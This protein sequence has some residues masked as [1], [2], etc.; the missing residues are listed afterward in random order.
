MQSALAHWTGQRTVPNVFI[1]GKH[2]GGCDCMCPF[3]PYLTCWFQLHHIYGHGHLLFSVI[4][5]LKISLLVH[6]ATT[7]L[8][9]EGKLVPLL[10]E[11]GALPPGKAT[12]LPSEK[13]TA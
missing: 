11:V 3:D 2:I 13:A 12:A 9:K 8:H 6:T 1:G 7:E 4:I 10:I 5:V